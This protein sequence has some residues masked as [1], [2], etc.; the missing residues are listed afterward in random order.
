MSNPKLE[1]EISDIIDK[2]IDKNEYYFKYSIENF[3]KETDVIKRSIQVDTL[4][5]IRKKHPNVDKHEATDKIKDMLNEKLI[6][7]VKVEFEE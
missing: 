7:M 2:N 4:D 6:I 1:K 3:I 5:S